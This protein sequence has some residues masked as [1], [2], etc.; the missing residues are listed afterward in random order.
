MRRNSLSPDGREGWG[1]GAIGDRAAVTL[2]RLAVRTASH[3]LPQCGRGNPQLRLGRCTGAVH[4]E[5]RQ[6]PLQSHALEALCLQE[7]FHEVAVLQREG[8]QRAGLPGELLR[9]FERAFEDEP[10][11][12]VDVDRRRL[13]AEPHRLQRDRTPAGERV[14]HPRRPPAIGLADLLPEPVEI[15][16]ALA[17][18]MQDAA[19]R[20]A[21]ALLDR[22]AVDLLFFDYL[23]DLAGEPPVDR[24]A[25]LVVA[26][27][28]QQGRDQRRAARRQRPPCRPDVQGRDMPVPDVLFVH[29]IERHLFQ[30]EIEL[31]QALHVLHCHFPSVFSE[32]GATELNHR[33]DA[34]ACRAGH[35]QARGSSRSVSVVTYHSMRARSPGHS[36]GCAK[37]FISE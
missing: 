33:E 15:G 34:P 31:D 24:L 37:S 26:G 32:S 6:L 36:S 29:R 11:D 28:G 3:P 17:P 16:T 9:V 2:T 10:G 23:H 14:E 7:G 12:R 35:R 19:A 21:L 1:E 20:L 25:L 5:L 4:P 8:G 22:L 13:A 18:P 30:R 27:V